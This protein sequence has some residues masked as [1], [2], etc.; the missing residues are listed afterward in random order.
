MPAG[1]PPNVLFLFTDDQRF[2]T[3]AALGNP[4]IRTPAL[5]RLCAEG[6]AFTRAHIMG[7]SCP[8]VCMPS[9][10]MLHTGRSLFHIDQQGQQ[11]PA[12]H[13]TLGECF[14]EAGYETF[15]TGKWHNGTASFARSFSAG[16]E[17]F[18]G[19]MA[20][21]W[22]VP[23][24][25]FDPAGRYEQ[26]PYCVDPW[27]SNEVRY[28]HCDHVTAG[29][30]SSDLLSDAAAGFLR[31]HGGRKPFFMYVSFLA[32]HD[33]RTMPQ[34][35]LDLYPPEQVPLPANFLPEHPFDNGEL[36]IR[37]EMLAGFPRGEREIRRHLAEYYAMITHADAAVGRILEAL[38][39]CGEYERTIIVFAGDNGLAIGR[40]GLM[41]KQNLYEH[42]VRV[43]LILAGP[44]VPAGQTRDTYGYLFDVFPTL[45]ELT[46]VAVPDSVEGRSLAP[47]LADAGCRVRDG[48]H[49][50]YRHCQ[51]GVKD[52]RWKL[53]EYVVEGRR[54]TQLFDLA[55]DPLEMTSLAGEPACAGHLARLRQEL[56]RWVDD[57]GDGGAFW[58]AW[59][60]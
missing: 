45:C 32:P 35:Y 51:R 21:H 25:D 29:R 17:I 27:R 59:K 13:V 2:D 49:L 52:G 15:G 36:R 4:H 12:G 55:A 6:T 31:D 18:F 53:I 54:T 1:R 3:V 10:A 22:N 50:A 40:H 41:G 5:D 56:A 47:A 7:G 23:A 46:G 14:R 43:P 38:R 48:V 11:I 34:E 33:P 42:S 28:R 37:D 57:L 20:D 58:E 24:C 30:H 16:A 39:A 60:G 26:R 8:A 9:R 19:G 44:G